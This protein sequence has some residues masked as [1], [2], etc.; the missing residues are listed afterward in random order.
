MNK[1]I[2]YNGKLNVIGN[3]VKR[4]RENG[5]I[6]IIIQIKMLLQ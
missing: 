6:Y 4:Y 5:D 1:I 2:K 3:N